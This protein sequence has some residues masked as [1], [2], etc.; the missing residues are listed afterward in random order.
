MIIGFCNQKFYNNQLIVL[1]EENGRENPLTVYKTV[2]GNHARGRYNQREIDEIKRIYDKLRAEQPEQSV[3]VV[4]P[5]REQA[6][7]TKDFL[8]N[9]N[10]EVDTVHKY[11]GREKDVIILTTVVNKMNDFVDNPNLINVA[12]SRAVDK[13]IIVTYG[14]KEDKNSNI[15]DLVKYIEYNNC[16]VVQ[17]DISSIFDLLYQDYN[18]QLLDFTKNRKKVSGY[19]SE[20]LMNKVIEEVL[21]FSG[22]QNLGFVVH[23]PLKTFINNFEKLN[24]EECKFAGNILTHVDFLIFNKMDKIP[25]LVVEVDGYS[26]HANNPKQLA[27]DK[28]K[29]K[30]LEKYDIPI[31]RLAT[32]ESREQERLKAKLI[33]IQG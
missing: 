20:N 18:K 10:I 5:Y 31:L 22:F 32:N 2:K 30:I 16:E 8:G 11:Q 6:H 27:R 1:T 25:V 7:R 19:E 33:D 15:G 14:N 13:L 26:Y 17:S 12:V 21:T 9:S 3:G 28:I 4:S 24:K 23:Q 29:D